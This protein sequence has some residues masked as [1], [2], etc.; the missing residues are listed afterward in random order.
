MKFENTKCK[1]TWNRTPPTFRVT[2][3]RSRRHLLSFWWNERGKSTFLSQS[4]SDCQCAG[5]FIRWEVVFGLLITWSATNK[6]IS[7][8]QIRCWTRVAVQSFYWRGGGKAEGAWGMYNCHHFQLLINQVL[9]FAIVTDEGRLPPSENMS[10]PLT[11]GVIVFFF[12]WF[13]TCC[14]KFYPSLPH[15]VFIGTRS[16]HSLHM[17]AT[18]SLIN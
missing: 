9:F 18:N 8:D 6:L 3:G 1:P 14:Q 5:W 2:R 4:I 16:D 7:L 15:P 17:S 10:R 11:A 12:L 13:S